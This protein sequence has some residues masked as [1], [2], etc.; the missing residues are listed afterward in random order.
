MK[1][2][3]VPISFLIVSSLLAQSSVA[4][5]EACGAPEFRQFDFW[6]G[7]W[8]VK[9]PEGKEIGTNEITRSAGGCV[10]EEHWSGGTG[11][12]GVSISFYDAGDAKWHQHWMG[13]DG[14]ALDLTGALSAQTMVLAQEHPN[15]RVDRVK[16][17]PLPDGKV[18][19]EWES[20]SDGGKVWKT[21]FV[22]IYERR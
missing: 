20:S 13:S 21:E 6:I 19:Q 14:Q 1:I 7:S 22:G 4:A 10:L 12:T 5:K 2:L 18:K 11:I 3:Y 8:T 17:T 15:H 16:W 9:N